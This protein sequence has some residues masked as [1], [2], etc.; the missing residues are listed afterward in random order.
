MPGI[1]STSG[2]IVEEGGKKRI[3][4][5]RAKSLPRPNLASVPITLQP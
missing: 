3:D 1:A 2:K 4:A 5:D